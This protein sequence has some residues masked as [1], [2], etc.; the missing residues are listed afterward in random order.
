M[1]KN[2]INVLFPKICLGCNNLL[3]TNEDL[4]CTICKH[5]LPLTNHHYVKSNDTKNKFYGIINF[6]F[7]CSMLYFNDKGIVKNIIHNLKYRGQQNLGTYLGTIYGNDL[8]E[9]IAHFNIDYIIPVPIHK[10]RLAERGYN[11]VTTF[12]EAFAEQ[13]N[14]KLIDN[15]L[16]RKFFSTT[17]TKKNRD[18]RQK[19]VNSLFDITYDEKYIGKHFLIVD[20]VITTG[21]TIEACAKALEK[22]PNAKLSVVSIAYTLS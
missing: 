7:A 11:Q 3:L 9:I 21:S 10:K 1:L 20:D 16:Y 22:I 13:T 6:E 5:S 12:C 19:A 4:L 2:L 17:Q 8:K 14:I 15:L 18:E